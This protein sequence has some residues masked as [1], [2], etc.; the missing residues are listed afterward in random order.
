LLDIDEIKFLMQT[1]VH[2]MIK[3]GTIII[4]VN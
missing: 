1:L 3:T 2:Q 4:F